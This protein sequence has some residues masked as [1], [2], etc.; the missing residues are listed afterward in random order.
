L[1]IKTN[2]ASCL[3]DLYSVVSRFG[4]KIS[5]EHGIGIK[6]R[7]YLKDLISPA[8]FALMR[9]LK[10]AWDPNHIMNPGKIFE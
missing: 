1:S 4:G 6:R 5:G 7:K 10:Q 3:G 2:E 8:E 9:S